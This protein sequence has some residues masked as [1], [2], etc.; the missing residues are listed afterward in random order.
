MSVQEVPIQ[1][2]ESWSEN[3]DV[4]MIWTITCFHGATPTV[5]SSV[6]FCVPCVP[7]LAVWCGTRLEEHN[8]VPVPAGATTWQHTVNMV[9]IVKLSQKVSWQNMQTR[10]DGLQDQTADCIQRIFETCAGP[11]KANFADAI[12]FQLQHVPCSDTK[13][14]RKQSLHS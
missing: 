7:G 3:N 13:E 14:S 8:P 1:Y 9:G 11:S 5:V 12:R 10:R 4:E 6:W 2:Q